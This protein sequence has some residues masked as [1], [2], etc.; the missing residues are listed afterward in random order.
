MPQA[1]RCVPAETVHPSGR[2]ESPEDGWFLHATYFALPYNG[3][4]YWPYSEAVHKPADL[5]RPCQ[6]AAE[7]REFPRQRSASC[8]RCHD[9]W[10]HLSGKSAQQI[11]HELRESHQ[12]LRR[13]SLWKARSRRRTN[14]P[15][16]AIRA[17]GF[18]PNSVSH[19][20]DFSWGDSNLRQTDRISKPLSSSTA[21]DSVLANN[22]SG[23]IHS[24]QLPP[25]P[26]EMLLKRRPHRRQRAPMSNNIFRSPARRQQQAYATCRCTLIEG[27]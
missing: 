20:Q 27:R 10:L 5:E 15:P 1:L 12:I 25:A 21:A 19:D 2:D 4:R 26:D 13:R 23:L 16:A 14:I 11:L 6:S 17:A 9:G 7:V 24:F 22:K 3:A 8:Q 18:G